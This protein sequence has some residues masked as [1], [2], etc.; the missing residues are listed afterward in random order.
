MATKI[1][2]I[3]GY[4]KRDKI[5]YLSLLAIAAAVTAWLFLK[6]GSAPQA[7]VAEP[8]TQEELVKLVKPSVVRII[9]HATGQ[10]AI[11][12]LD[13]DAKNLA[14]NILPG[15]PLNIINVD[16]YVAGSGFIVNP[17]GYILTNSHVISQETIKEL[18]LEDALRSAIEAKTNS[19][20]T[21][22]IRNLFPSQEALA[23]FAAQSLDLVQ[24]NSSFTLKSVITVLNPSASVDDLITL[25]KTG[26]IANII[27]IN[28]NFFKD[29]KDV[30]LIKIAGRNLPA[31]QL[32]DAG[33]VNVGN[34][35]YVFGFPAT[36]ELNGR[37]PLESTFTQG[38]VSAIKN[39]QNREFKV[40]QTDAKISQG[41][42]GGPLFNNKGEVVG[43]VTFQTSASLQGIGD[44]FAFAVPVNLAQEVL[45]KA[46]V[47]NDTN[48]YWQHFQT[49]LQYFNKGQCRQAKTEL[50]LAALANRDFAAGQY[51]NPYLEQC[52]QIIFNGSSIGSNYRFALSWLQTISGFAWF[53]IIGRIILI[54]AGILVLAKGIKRLRKDER[55]I[56]EMEAELREEEREKS[57]LLGQLEKKGIPL[58]LPDQ[59]L[60]AD[61]RLALNIPHPHV[62]QFVQEAKTIGMKDRHISE[63]L[64]K[65]GW[66]EQD[67]TN[68][69]KQDTGAASQ[70]E[71]PAYVL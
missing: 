5:F 43:I 68:A 10:A 45:Q 28:E 42:S 13:F 4:W 54:F 58:P 69:L 62:A 17:D 71:D 50:T 67:I 2:T 57:K 35:I 56:V 15:K 26:F 53:V 44:N 12:Q 9:Q 14:V 52:D 19:L 39:S 55:E 23:N 65:A 27:S 18:Y 24:K 70:A 21:E 7:A 40:F 59:E 38:I 60:H 31:V 64:A 51:I 22:E 48:G 6:H 34:K 20:S 30:G 32:G 33:R 63:E 36:A 25:S 1:Q 3:A 37:S 41:S 47:S 61:H 8:L 29:E 46:R 49:G 11:P 66:K 16:E